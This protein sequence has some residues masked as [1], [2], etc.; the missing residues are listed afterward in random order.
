MRSTSRSP[1]ESANCARD[2]TRQIATPSANIGLLAT[3]WDVGGHSSTEMA[4]RVYVSPQADSAEAALRARAR[5]DRFK[6]GTEPPQK[7]TQTSGV[8]FCPGIRGKDGRIR[9]C[10]LCLRR[11]W[12]EIAK[13]SLSYI[14]RCKLAPAK[15]RKGP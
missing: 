12:D 4:G 8:R 2:R 11:A 5:E 9:T 14:F 3:E 6:P 10:D 1:I 7:L 13:A 15:C